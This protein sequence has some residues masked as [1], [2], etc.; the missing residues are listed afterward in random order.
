MGSEKVKTGRRGVRGDQEGHEIGLPL[1]ILAARML[2][3]SNISLPPSL[4]LPLF[5]SHCTASAVAMNAV[6]QTLS[7]AIL[8][9]CSTVSC[10]SIIVQHGF[11][12]QY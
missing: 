9:T 11:T 5:L 8:I 12:P 7:K 3:L 1:P 10:H 2:H 4:L 6:Y